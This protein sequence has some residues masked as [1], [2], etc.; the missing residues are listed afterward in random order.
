MRLWKHG[1]FLQM[2]VCL[3]S[4]HINYR[5]EALLDSIPS[6]VPAFDTQKDVRMDVRI[7]RQICAHQL[8]RQPRKPLRQTVISMKLPVWLVEKRS[9]FP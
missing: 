5:E 9:V 1:Y 2:V 6:T 7:Q 8:S 4:S 3:L